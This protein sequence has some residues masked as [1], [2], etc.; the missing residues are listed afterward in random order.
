MK[1]FALNHFILRV[2]DSIQHRKLEYTAEIVNCYKNGDAMILVQDTPQNSKY[3]DGLPKTF[4]A[5]NI[6][7]HFII[8]KTKYI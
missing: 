4:R 5:F 3:W 1:T 7:K 8:I 2:G 6:A